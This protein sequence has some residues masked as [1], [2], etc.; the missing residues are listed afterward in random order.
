MAA[1]RKPRGP[2]RPRA[3]RVAGTYQA[4]TGSVGGGELG[5]AAEEIAEEARRLGAWSA[6]I[7]S[8]IAVQVDGGQSWAEI[9][10]DAGPAYPAETGAR[11]PLFGDREHWYPPSAKQRPF[12]AP[13]ADRRAGAAMAKYAQKID[14]LCR[15]KG[16]K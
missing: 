2:R 9:S 8:S 11:H 13:A 12:L 1:P 7:A 5:A 4:T 16:F 6:Q 15:E 14:R 10:C 3:P